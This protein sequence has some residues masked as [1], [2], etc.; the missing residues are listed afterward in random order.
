MAENSNIPWTDHTFNPWIG[1]AQI[2][3]GCANCYAEVQDQHWKWTSAG[4][5]RGKPRRRTS[6]AYW[7]EPL[8][9]NRQAEAEGRRVKVF[10]ASLADVFDHEVPKAWR[11]DL[12]DLIRKTPHLDWI[13]VTKR[14]ENAPAMLPADWGRG[15]PNVWLVLTVCNQNE[16]DKHVGNFLKI[17]AAIHGLS[18][19]PLLD[20]I[21][22]HSRGCAGDIDWYIVGAESGPGARPMDIEWVRS[23]RGQ[24]NRLRHTEPHRRQPALFYKQQI[25]DGK[26]A[27]CPQLDGRQWTEFPR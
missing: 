9:W 11:E 1:C 16:F 24:L 22:I 19:E 18:I 2:G 23:L 12:W 20:W 5:G 13:I 6:A 8:K 3:P 25:V 10:S 7:R 17:P 26:K 15:W 21:D 4:W 14:I 27:E